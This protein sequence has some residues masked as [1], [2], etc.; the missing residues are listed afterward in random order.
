MYVEVE[1]FISVFGTE[2]VETGDGW[3]GVEDGATGLV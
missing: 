1:S 3:E 2:A